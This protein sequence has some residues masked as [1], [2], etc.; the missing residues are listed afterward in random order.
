MGV[1]VV[2]VKMDSDVCIHWRRML[3]FVPTIFMVIQLQLL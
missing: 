1:S 3:Y 2:N